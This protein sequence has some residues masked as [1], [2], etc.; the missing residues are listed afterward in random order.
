[1]NRG[2]IQYITHPIDGVSYSEQ[3]EDV[4][5][6]GIRWIQ[7]RMKSGSREHA[8]EEAKKVQLICKRYGAKFIVNDSVE[9]AKSLGADGVHLGLNDMDPIEARAILGP[10][11]TIGATCNNFENITLR[12]EQ[13]VDYIG[14]GPFRYTDTK[15]NLSPIL[16]LEGYSEIISQCRERGIDIPIVAIGGIRLDD[17][18]PIVD[19]GVYGVAISS[20]ITASEDRVSQARSIATCDKL[21]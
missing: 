9:F 12:S 5:K 20:L 15:Q 2:K 13:R 4:C 14:L 18:T 11:V 1:M 3:C 7:F 6:G 8:L 19:T 16:G 17:I 21:K 10:D